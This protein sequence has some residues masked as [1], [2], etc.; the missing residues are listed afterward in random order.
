MLFPANLQKIF[1]FDVQEQEYLLPC[2]PLLFQNHISGKLVRL[3]IKRLWIP[4]LLL[5]QETFNHHF[6]GEF[7][8]IFI[9]YLF[10]K[11]I[12]Q[13]LSTYVCC[14]LLSS[15]HFCFHHWF[16]VEIGYESVITMMKAIRSFTSFVRFSTYNWPLILEVF[17]LRL[18]HL[19]EVHLVL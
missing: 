1:V 18:P 12:T 8:G 11:G 5:I 9:E 3:V 15:I 6:Y 7:C 14:S 13:P 19:K 2:F 17:Y 10:I 16:E 4:N